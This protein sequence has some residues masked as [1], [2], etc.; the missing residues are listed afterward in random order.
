MIVTCPFG[1]T[2]VAAPD[3]LTSPDDLTGATNLKRSASLLEISTC[4]AGRTGPKIRTPAKSLP[5]GLITST[6]SSAAY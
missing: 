5:S 6:F 3:P 2:S 1:P 4:E